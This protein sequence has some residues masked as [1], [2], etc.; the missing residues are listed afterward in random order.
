[1]GVSLDVVLTIAHYSVALSSDVYLPRLGAAGM[2]LA[3]LA[4]ALFCVLY[5]RG[6]IIE[7]IPASATIVVWLSAPQAV[8]V[9]SRTTDPYSWRDQI[10]GSN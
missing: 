9:T 3:A 4:I 5:R 10:T 6:R 8:W 1:M 2:G 7:I